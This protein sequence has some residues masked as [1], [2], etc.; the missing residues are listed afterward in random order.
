M[1]NKVVRLVALRLWP[2]AISSQQ[3]NAVHFGLYGVDVAITE[4]KEGTSEP[5]V[6]ISSI[7]FSSQEG[8]SEEDT[9]M[10]KYLGIDP[11]DVAAFAVGG[12]EKLSAEVMCNK[13]KAGCRMLSAI[14]PFLNKIEYKIGVLVTF[15]SS[16]YTQPI[17]VMQELGSIQ[18]GYCKQIPAGEKQAGKSSFYSVWDISVNR[19]CNTDPY[20]F[21]L[22]PLLD[23][24]E[25]V[26]LENLKDTIISCFSSYN[27][28]FER[29]ET[30]VRVS[31]TCKSEG[32]YYSSWNREPLLTGEGLE[33]AYTVPTPSYHSHGQRGAKPGFGKGKRSGKLEITG[34]VC[35]CLEY[36]S[37]KGDKPAVLKWTTRKSSWSA[38]FDKTLVLRG[39]YALPSDWDRRMICDAFDRMP[40]LADIQKMMEYRGGAGRSCN[41]EFTKEDAA[42]ILC[43][44][45]G[46]FKPEDANIKHLLEKNALTSEDIDSIINNYVLD[47]LRSERQVSDLVQNVLSM[48]ETEAGR[49]EDGVAALSMN[50]N[51]LDG[52]DVVFEFFPFTDING[53]D[54]CYPKLVSV[55]P[56]V[57]AAGAIISVPA[58]G[59]V[60]G[61]KKKLPV[62][63]LTPDFCDKTWKDV[64]RG[65]RLP[66]SVVQLEGGKHGGVFSDFGK[67]EIVDLTACTGLK[68]IGQN[69]FKNCSHLHSILLP[70]AEAK[71]SYTIHEKAF[72]TLPSLGTLKIRAKEILNSAFLNVSMYSL[73]LDA[74]NVGSRAFY[75]DVTV[76]SDLI[77]GKSFKNIGSSGMSGLCTGHVLNVSFPEILKMEDNAIRRDGDAAGTVE[78]GSN[79]SSLGTG[80]LFGWESV[81]VNSAEI[82]K[83]G[84]RMRKSAAATDS[85]RGVG[86]VKVHA[87][88]SFE[89]EALKSLTPD[90][91]SYF[92]GEEGSDRRKEAENYIQLSSMFFTN[93]E[94]TLT[95]YLRDQLAMGTD[96]FCPPEELPSLLGV[97]GGA[98][99][100]GADAATFFGNG[101]SPYYEKVAEDRGDMSDTEAYMDVAVLR[102]LMAI[103]EP[104]PKNLESLYSNASLYSKSFQHTLVYSSENMNITRVK[105]ITADFRTEVYMYLVTLAE[106]GETYL[107]VERMS[108]VRLVSR[109]EVCEYLKVGSDDLSKYKYKEAPSFP[110]PKDGEDAPAPFLMLGDDLKAGNPTLL[111]NSLAD[112]K[113][114]YNGYMK[115]ILASAVAVRTDDRYI[116]FN[117]FMK[118]KISFDNKKELARVHESG[119]ALTLNGFCKE[120]SER[121]GK[122][123]R[124]ITDAATFSSFAKLAISPQPVQESNFSIPLSIFAEN[125]TSVKGKRSVLPLSRKLFDSLT[126]YGSYIMSKHSG[127]GVLASE[128]NLN[129]SMSTAR[130]LQ[131]ADGLYLQCFTSSRVSKGEQIKTSDVIDATRAS[132]RGGRHQTWYRLFV[133]PK[134]GDAIATYISRYE[135]SDL[136]KHLESFDFSKAGT[137]AAI[138]YGKLVDRKRFIF[139]TESMPVF[140]DALRY[141]GENTDWKASV[142]CA[143]DTYTGRWYLVSDDIATKKNA[144]KDDGE[145]ATTQ[146]VHNKLLVLFPVANIAFASAVVLG[147]ASTDVATT[148]DYLS[149]LLDEL[150]RS[151]KG[152]IYQDYQAACSELSQAEPNRRRIVELTDFFLAPCLG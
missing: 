139:D 103:T 81:I 135:V 73:D 76:E 46:K 13:M 4:L 132:Y 105:F 151:K 101:E 30:S 57:V 125:K 61:H 99:P 44:L 56:E 7:S 65:V 38:K 152:K 69:T 40:R 95:S 64:L 112:M 14:S 84:K 72:D 136:V 19:Y 114:S 122:A 89:T 134:G 117:P 123:P 59:T 25:E 15:G 31:F 142:G 10:V 75:K 3:P 18:T 66:A 70:D 116:L 47:A 1:L 53:K 79:L 35:A 120:L 50:G 147:L 23:K 118:W 96:L 93:N 100:A 52:T 121:K 109:G 29:G 119:I 137:A 45:L 131:L 42:I 55:S 106:S 102:A 34:G 71:D 24:T 91:I 8:L 74:E 60:A 113:S 145:A 37:P 51:I 141:G 77:I 90:K 62:V 27:R 138:E 58:M 83:K 48:C 94:T 107:L 92:E 9:E 128:N 28:R 12:S 67:L 144:A 108:D 43:V 140:F 97:L 20:D 146:V 22:L 149:E 49:A 87:E 63:T 54:G 80:A 126:Q 36:T 111:G 88:T 115:T 124:M 16:F 6:R 110:Y 32:S 129:V 26:K 2:V 133:A 148:K 127:T 33:V 98:Y 85:F 78:L 143:I 11:A 21:S 130:R 150:R 5:T 68:Q 86:A 17:S 39:L 104:L 41:D 82:D